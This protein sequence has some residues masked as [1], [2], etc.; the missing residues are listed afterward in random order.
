VS[1]RTQA[2]G[3]TLLS[4]KTIDAECDED[5]RGDDFDDAIDP[6]GQEG[7][8]GASDADGLENCPR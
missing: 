3:K 7:R 8:V 1:A 2:K 5:A 6:G 4:P